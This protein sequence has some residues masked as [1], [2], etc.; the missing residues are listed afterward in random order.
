MNYSI[1]RRMIGVILVI[2]ALFLLPSLFLSLFDQDGITRYF[3]ISLILMVFFGYMAY[4]K[5]ATDLVLSPK[6]G[7]FIVS[8]AWLIV[9]LFGALPFYLSHYLS[10][11]DAFFEI[12][13]GF[14]TTGASIIPNIE[15]FPRSLILWRS[16]THWIGGMGILVFTISLLPRLG[17]GGFQIF[18]A[19]SPGPIAGK[20]EPRIADTAK[21]LY[22]IYI[23]ITVVLFFLLVLGKMT[24]FDALIHTL[25]VAGT[26]GFSSKANSIGAYSGYYIPIIMSIFMMVYGT[27]FSV[28]YQLSQKKY[29]SILKNDEVRL[30]YLII[31]VAVLGI[32]WNL[33]SNHYGSL[34]Q[35]V[36]DS[37]FQVTSL[38]STSGFSNTDYDLWPSFSKFILYALMFTGACAGSTAGGMK[39]VR[40]SIV[41]KLIAREIG[42][43][44]HPNAV[45]P[46]TL[47]G[48][49]LKDEVVM[50]VTAFISVYLMI[51][52][53]SSALVTMSGLD[54]LSSCS[55]VTTM[56]SNVG[57]GFNKVGPSLNF[58]EFS[59][60]YKLY[61]SFLM[62]LGRLE[63][64]T[65]LGILVPRRQRK[66]LQI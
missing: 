26:G 7:L 23:G 41:F 66:K 11:V 60:F 20:I 15:L 45:I 44:V 6:D 50:G 47:E 5:K 29:K 43:V 38:M 62:L 3:L 13:S 33:Y 48:K 56:L 27:N 54:V 46:V 28:Y 53:F 4:R 49:A 2:E 65:I 1:A 31:I 39:I 14:T 42:K 16:V 52:V 61:F 58:S 55:A 57:P 21:R 24:P 30:Y 22:I 18:K 37:F 34:G 51:F 12:V 35:S 36:K 25:G 10:Y 19:E 17:V 9:S 64:F 63:F 59:D 40:I 32:T 8:S